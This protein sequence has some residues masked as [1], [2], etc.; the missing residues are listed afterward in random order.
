[1]R[2]VHLHFYRD[3]PLKLVEKDAGGEI[4]KVLT[5]TETYEIEKYRER[6][7]ER[8]SSQ[9][10]RPGSAAR[11][12]PNSGSLPGSA[13]KLRPEIN[14]NIRLRPDSGISTRSRPDSGITSLRSR[15]DSGTTISLRSRPD[16]GT[17]ISLRSRPDSGHSSGVYSLTS[18]STF[19]P[20]TDEINLS[21]AAITET[22]AGKHIL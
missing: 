15:P 8:R 6:L 4:S 18:A 16:S 22:L 17:T 14:Q 21:A 2:H 12:R 19:D 10:S 5:D 7:Q 11:S 1:M 9:R 13:S 20:D 3:E